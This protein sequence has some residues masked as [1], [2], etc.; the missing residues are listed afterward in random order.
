[1]FERPMWTPSYGSFYPNNLGG[2]SRGI[3]N[4]GL[5][6]QSV[7]G[8][9]IRNLGGIKSLTKGIDWGGLF[10][11]AQ[12]TLGIVNQAIPLVKEAK[13]MFNNMKTMLK[14]ATAFKDETASEKTPSSKISKKETKK[15]E[16]IPSSKNVNN[17][18]NT[19]QFFL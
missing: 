19:P 5:G 17:N 8:L 18:V 15:E 9:G 13:P 1:M 2:L 6:T 16:T 11:G 3:G 10:S 7:R 14:L 4:I 12:K